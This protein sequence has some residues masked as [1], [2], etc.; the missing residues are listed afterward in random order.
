M[1]NMSFS[2]TEPQLLDGTK[3]VTRRLGWRFLDYGDRVCAVRKAMG[4][5]KGEKVHRLGICEILDVC[6]EPLWA[7]TPE[8]CRAEGFP[9]MTPADFVA[10]FSREMRTTPN[11]LVTR[12]EFTFTPEPSQGRMIEWNPPSSLT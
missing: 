3:T 1:R 10:F 9:E 2:K 8:D 4:L 7:I 5:A 11:T 12:I 6:R